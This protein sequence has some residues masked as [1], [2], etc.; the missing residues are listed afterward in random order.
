MQERKPQFL[1]SRY[2]TIL[3]ILDVHCLLTSVEARVH[4]STS[5]TVMVV[6]AESFDLVRSVVQRPNL[7]AVRSTLGE[8]R[9]Q[10]TPLR[11]ALRCSEACLV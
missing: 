3:Y 4:G 9:S 5:L 6:T 8:S 2:C 1:H 11:R 10:Q 7:G